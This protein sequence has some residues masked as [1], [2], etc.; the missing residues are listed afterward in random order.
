[1]AQTSSDFI[2]LRDDCNDGDDGESLCAV[3]Q[4]I[5]KDGFKIPRFNLNIYQIAPYIDSQLLDA[6]RIEMMKM[7]NMVKGQLTQ[8]IY[9]L[10]K[11]DKLS[12][13]SLLACC[14]K[15]TAGTVENKYVLLKRRYSVQEGI[16][17]DHKRED[18]PVIEPDLVYDVIIASHLIN[19]HLKWRKIHQHMKGLFANV[20][21]DFANLA[22]QYCSHCNSDRN[23][24]Q[25]LRYKH[26]NVNENIMPLERCHI[27]IFSPFDEDGCEKIG[28][29]YS[30]VLYCRD[31][32][33]RFVWMLPLKSIKIRNLMHSLTKM[34][35]SMIRTPIFIETATLDRQDMFDMCEH[36]ARKYKLRLGL[37]INNG[38][39][40]QKNGVRRIKD[41]FGEYKENCKDDWNMCLR[42]ILDRLNH[43]YSDRVRGIPSDLLCNRVLNITQKFKQKQ[44][45]IIDELY[46]NNVVQFKEAGG[47]IYLEEERN[48]D[49]M[50]KI[51]TENDTSC[52]DDEEPEQL[53]NDIV[54]E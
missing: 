10:I 51:R 42:L 32:H 46:A 44:R 53:M 4:S 2:K 11:S 7:I 37:G 18:L 27:E 40:F 36:I 50:K 41:L 39:E 12:R 35:C 31:Y 29:K 3:Y 20:T 26:Y 49:S 54:K 33:S 45:K 47:I 34:L 21:R 14:D 9:S 52:V 24:K 28:G 22:T 25:F 48:C 30:H 16:V 19:N 38:T 23:M 6:G 8:A 15:V 1:M 17:V 13:Q 5:T 43:A